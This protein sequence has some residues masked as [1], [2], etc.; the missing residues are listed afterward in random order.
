MTALRDA[1]ASNAGTVRDRAAEAVSTLNP[2]YFAFV[3]GTGIVSVGMNNHGLTVLSLILLW[4]AV[5]GYVVLIALHVWRFIAYRANLWADFTDPRRAFGFF[6]FVAGTDVLGTRTVLASHRGIAAGLLVVG[7][8]GW[9]VLGY[10]VPWTAVL[11][12]RERP[13]VAAAN[14]TWFI[15]VVA[16][17]SVAVLAST[18]EPAAHTGKEELDLLA[19]FSWSVGVFLYAAAGV[20]VAARLMLY[21]LEPQDLT[22]PY[23]VAMGATAITVLAGAR[24]V[25]MADAPMVS[26]TRGLIAGTSAIFWAFGTWLIPVLFAAGWWRHAVHRIPL[27]YE[28]TWWS[29]VFPLGMYGVAGHYIGRADNLPI[30]RSIGENETWFALGFWVCVFVAMVVHLWRTLAMSRSSQ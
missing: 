1:T 28:A 19:V 3:M 29:I 11:G 9:L 8:L 25:Q 7:W 20:F 4:L 23:W 18:L 30:V 21:P 27:R 26:V 14:G 24:I 17:Q 10:V 13:V 16:S 12:R 15:W 6:T 2:G 22:P 5:V